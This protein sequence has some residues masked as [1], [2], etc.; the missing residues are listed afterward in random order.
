MS[1]A[2][3]LQSAGDELE[4]RLAGGSPAAPMT[5][6]AAIARP[7]PAED[8]F[9]RPRQS[10]PA[11]EI[12]RLGE[13][14]E[15]LAALVERHAGPRSEPKAPADRLADAGKELQRRQ[16]ERL[17]AGFARP[18]VASA[19]TGELVAG[20]VDLD[21]IPAT[22][23][24]LNR[25]EWAPAVVDLE[26]M[27]GIERWLHEVAEDVPAQMQAGLDAD[28]MA[29]LAYKEM[30]GEPL[31]AE[32][33]RALERGL[34]AP[35]AMTT[36]GTAAAL[37][38]S[39]LPTVGSAVQGGLAGGSAGAALG[40]GAT[41]AAGGVGAVPGAVF[42]ATAGALGGG[43]LHSYQVN[44]GAAWAEYG[45]LR[46]VDGQGLDP[47]IRKGG[48]MLAGVLS[49][50][51]DSFG[52]GYLASKVPGLRA[53]SGDGAK[54]LVRRLLEQPSM[55]AAVKRFAEAYAGGIVVETGTEVL[56]ETAQ[57]A[58]GELLKVADE[59]EFASL[60]AEEITERLGGVAAQTARGM[61]LLAIPGP[62]MSFAVDARAALQAGRQRDA[63]L[64]LG[65][66]AKSSKLEADDP[67]A[68]GRFVAELQSETGAAVQDVL[69]DAEAFA[70]FFQSQ[71][72]DP[73]LAAAEL[74][75]AEQYSRAAEMGG[76]LAVPLEA[77]ARRI[78][79]SD[80]H[81][82]LADHVRL[83]PEA[84]TAA[85]ARTFAQEVEELAEAAGGG[86]VDVTSPRA[87]ILA[88]AEAQLADAGLAPDAARAN[89]ELWANLFTV[90]GERAGVDPVELWQRQ[91]PN[92]RR[93]SAAEVLPA[94]E[95]RQRQ[96]TSLLAFL[97][98]N[99]GLQDDAGELRSRDLQKQRPGLVSKKGRNLDDATLA[100]WE[101]GYLG[102]RE[103]PRPTPNALLAAID[104]ELA[105]RKVFSLADS[106][107]A[108]RFIDQQERAAVDDELAY[109]RDEVL[110][111]AEALGIELDP[112]RVDAVLDLAFADSLSV[113]DAVERVVMADAQLEADG[114]DARPREFFQPMIAGLDLSRVVEIIDA[115]DLGA[116]PREAKAVAKAVAPVEV[117]NADTGRRLVMSRGAADHAVSSF[118]KSID[119]AAHLDATVVIP[120][121]LEKAI[122]IE[123]HA[124]REGRREIR[125]VHRF[126]APLRH[127]GQVY[128]AK[129]TVR[130]TMGGPDEAT[131]DGVY[132]FYDSKIEQRVGR[133]ASPTPATRVD[134]STPPPNADAPGS[135]AA[136]PLT[137]RD[138][139]EGLKDEDGV[140]YFQAP[141]G[142]TRR[143]AITFVPGR[144]PLIRLFEESDLSTVLHE[145]GHLFLEMLGD[146]AA[147]EDAP[148]ALKSDYRAVLD[149]LGVEERSQIGTEQHEKL[150]RGFEAWLMEG[151]APSLEL[152]TVFQRFRSW[153]SLIYRSV[154][155]LNVQL[156]DDVRQ[157]FDRMVATDDA[158]AAAEAAMKFEPLLK[159]PVAGVSDGERRA[160]LDQAERATLQATRDV[161]EQ[162]RQALE[163]ERSKQFKDALERNRAA[164]RKEAEQLPA[165]RAMAFFGK[166]LM[167]G[168]RAPDTL[169]EIKLDRDAVRSEYGKAKLAALD[170]KRGEGRLTGKGGITPD[171]AAELLGFSSGDALI[172]AIID[173]PDRATL[174]HDRAMQRTRDELGEALKDAPLQ[175]AAR[176]AVANDERAVFLSAE[177]RLLAKA[178]GQ[179]AMPLQVIRAA[180]AKA[181]AQMTVRELMSHDRH[182]YTSQTFAKEAQR[183]FKKGDLSAAQNAKNKQIL[184]FETWRIAKKDRDKAEKS[185]EKW[186]RIAKGP[187]KNLPAGHRDQILTLL[188]RFELKKMSRAE[189]ERRANLGDWIRAQEANGL[190]VDIPEHIQSET[191]RRHYTELAVED[192]MALRDAIE[193]IEHLGK[194]E[195]KLLANTRQADLESAAAA[196]TAS[197]MDNNDWKPLRPDFAP[198][199]ME[200][201]KRGFAGF[202][203]AHAKV[204][205]LLERLDGFKLGAVWDTLFRPLAEAQGIEQQRQGALTKAIGGIF[206]KYSRLER[207][208]MHRRK[209]Y[210]QELGRDFTKGSLLALALNWGNEG[211]RLAVMKGYGWEQSRVQAALEAHLDQRDWRAVQEI[212]DLVDS[213]WPEIAALQAELTGAT[214]PKVEAT[215]IKTPF[216]ELEGGY[217]PLHYDSDLSFKA[218]QREEAQATAELF[219]GQHAR[220]ATRKGHTIARVGSGGQP[221]RLELGVLPQHLGQVVH[222]LTHRRAVIDTA[223]LI[224]KDDV[225]DAIEMAAGREVYR[226]LRPWLQS[227]AA[228]AYDPGVG[229]E[230]F[231][232]RAR[233]GTTIVNMG[234]KITTAIVQPLG[235]LTT[236]SFLGPKWAALGLKEVF[237]RGPLSIV[238]A[239]DFAFARSP[240][241]AHRAKSFDR[242]VKD[243]VRRLT[244]TGPLSG[245]ELSYFWL[246]GMLD[247]AVALPTWHGAYQKAIVA[248]P[249]APEADAVAA[250]DAAVRM[251]QSAGGMKDLARLQR[252]SELSRIFTMF[253]SWFSV[254]FNQFERTF[255]KTDFKRPG[256]YPQ[257]VG[258]MAM[259]WLAPAILG[260]LVAGRGPE[261]DEEL[262]LWA[263]K[264]LLA[265]PAASVVGLRD[266]VGAATSDFGFEL[267]PISDAFAGLARTGADLATGNFDNRSAVQNAFLTA[268]IWGRLPGRQIWITGEFF[269]D[270]LVNDAAPES[271]GEA[272]RHALLQRRPADER[273]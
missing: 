90:M 37:L 172:Q 16:R 218:F 181:V 117:V 58:V 233:S 124:D 29:R 223:R 69:V 30:L 134:G 81:A 153:L 17:L 152:R 197:I 44:A 186:K 48:A 26:A 243:T 225:R 113:D 237:G 187:V 151:K 51:L 263:G 85:Q 143:G 252:G 273:S 190:Q 59:N 138:L 101:A 167:D 185:I 50:G 106:K 264:Q 217:Y 250:A 199:G 209:I 136:A 227:I 126:F 38:G 32:D 92:V 171:Q 112:R 261:D 94:R 230:A 155:R 257:F 244:K 103:G 20:G 21:A 249:G 119:A 76:D 269:W 114:L 139:L 149:W 61:A 53:L 120:A 215:K 158:I 216:G 198:S 192:F 131:V 180:A 110:G 164:I 242:D 5:G 157:V 82:A 253:Y 188:E 27:G 100:A 222:D 64:R 104:D 240:E 14:P 19:A 105:G 72:A 71:G 31:S 228:P 207:M 213:F 196:V 125:K 147:A 70:T 140:S 6:A 84:M 43:V 9:K 63:Y 144:R 102:S 107:E 80:A 68:F 12:A 33:R 195:G 57:L 87:T 184:H 60:T 177:L 88:D 137:L 95:T 25:P 108:E 262:G 168:E 266:I 241:L 251:T 109:R 142:T 89:A 202:M 175:G 221:V 256:D 13:L 159:D 40:F 41:L 66:L 10:R 161:E 178:A 169:Q 133:A 247:M 238:Q 45:E 260:E 246:T 132:R 173:A 28:A 219:G 165:F 67:A 224:A 123:E 148:A 156:T 22:E 47:T 7:K 231:L 86:D 8:L 205:F 128:A 255:R 254:L 141:K 65:E 24:L 79:G 115:P 111:V 208:A 145:T 55:H 35:E 4:R 229:I 91:G 75:V 220:A 83:T 182:L 259:L 176:D 210:V 245:L 270:W 154:K 204:E 127:R 214:P 236:V 39:M 163:R 98:G 193:H 129:L 121:L 1:A 258:A 211:N 49:A 135:A 191:M 183:A 77:W 52:L 146:L 3:D 206:G 36:P 179:V 130:E 234:L 11:R 74:G 23:R 170:G 226:L 18:G 150:A 73:A 194:L 203:A 2:L 232:G 34:G 248:D 118:K 15:N 267:S 56:Q 162:Q 272:L 268:S 265:Y 93:G 235:Y 122:R 189:V 62:A 239:R 97:R 42:G 271:V 96:P 54:A 46:S 99:G 166:G 174:I 160:A 201:L 116:N 200:R 78:A 212:F